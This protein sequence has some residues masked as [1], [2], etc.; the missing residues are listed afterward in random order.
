MHEIYLDNNATTKPLDEVAEAMAA[1]MNQDYGNPSSPHGRGA[2]A[3]QA[4]QEARGHVAS[5][6]GCP[7]NGVIFTSGGTEANNL[8][9][10]SLCKPRHDSRLITCSTEH[11][12]VLKTAQWLKEQDVEVEV[13]DVDDMGFVN[14]NSLRKALE[15]PASLVSIQWSNSET[16]TIQPILKVGQLCKEHLVPFHADAAQAVGR[17]E[18]DLAKLPIAYLTF[19]AHK[20]HGPQGVGAVATLDRSHLQPMF[21][22]GDQ[23]SGIRPGTENLAGIVG[24]GKAALLRQQSLS[25]NI[26]KLRNLRNT[27]EEIVLAGLKQDL[28]NGARKD[29]ERAVNTTNIRFPEVDGMAMVAQLNQAGICCSLTSACVSSRPEPSHV[30]LAMGLSEESA[31]SSIRFSFSILNNEDEAKQ[32]A[33]KVTETYW[34]LHDLNISSGMRA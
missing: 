17:M 9:L 19:T 12:S 34:R 24:F 21:Q 5:L 25:D 32:A 28:V 3:R 8:V 22:G 2:I 7:E 14:L 1:A 11:S 30:L 18:I 10:Q 33:H 16:G 29:R 20:L 13:L 4:L 15:R 6:V 23:E 26:V 27:F 31:Y